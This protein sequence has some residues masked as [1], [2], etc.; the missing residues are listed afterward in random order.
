MW[1]NR[2]YL[3]VLILT[4]GFGSAMAGNDKVF[5]EKQQWSKYSKGY[6]YTE[7]LKKLKE[8]APKKSKRSHDFN[9]GKSFF[10]FGGSWLKYLLWGIVIVMLLVA[11]TW[12][13]VNIFKGSAEKVSNS[14]I[15][16]SLSVE[17]IEEAD[18]EHFL[19]ESLTS[20]SFKEA[21]RIRYL[22]LIRTLSRLNL[23][24]WKKDKTNGAYVTEMYG[25]VGFDLFC[26]LTISFERA[27][28]GEKQ[29]GEAEY[30][31]IIPVFD[32][33]NKTVMPNE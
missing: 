28:Y 19:D 27:W 3:I 31:S 10:S 29:I 2:L 8:K 4:I 22:M 30:R 15:F 24:T 14:K 1:V 11:I 5:I 23:V 17:D 16:K 26:Q 18:L 32:Q 25:K 12:L 13:V 9:F 33:M 6:D 7:N 21:I 20:G